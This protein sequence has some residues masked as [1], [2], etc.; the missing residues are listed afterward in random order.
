MLESLVLDATPLLTQTYAQLKPYA[1]KFYTTPGVRAELKD[2]NVKQQL[3]IW[4]DSLEV[5][6][7]KQKYVDAVW[8]FAR[9]TGDNQVLSI[10]DVHIIA[11]GAQIHDELTK[12]GSLDRLRTKP[13]ELRPIDKLRIEKYNE[14][15]RQ[16]QLENPRSDSYREDEQEDDGPVIDEDGFEVVV[17]KKKGKKG[18]RKQELASA[19]VVSETIET[20]TN[21]EDQENSAEQDPEDDDSALAQDYNP[22]DDDG[23]WITEDNIQEMVIKHNDNVEEDVPS[24]AAAPTGEATDSTEPAPVAATPVPPEMQQTLS[25]ISTGDY[26]CQNVSL[27]MGLH[28]LNPANGK[29]IKRVRNYML[30]CH[31]CF[32]IYPIPKD[33]TAKQFCP[34][35][36]GATLRRIPV[37]VNGVTGKITPHLSKNF[38]WITRGNVYSAP[39]P[40]SKRSQ[41]RYGNAGFNHSRGSNQKDFYSEDQKEYQQALKSAQY[42]MKKHE[43]DMMEYVSQGGSA[44]NVI[45]PFTS[46]NGGRTIKVKVGRGKYA[47]KSKRN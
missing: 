30:R 26:A 22:D 8:S 10:N 24:T 31:A 15:K 32:E 35:C 33:G 23:E 14:E 21:D 25:A 42:Q 28:L 27:Q 12:E 16:K 11:L 37:S 47:N 41:K 40:L 5:V 36:G 9:K 4:G 34:S 29:Q 13:G 7:P 38:Q 1:A 17:S 44:E 43:K 19:P 6:Q 3:L 2:D 18:L 45:S 46:G 20:E 39:N